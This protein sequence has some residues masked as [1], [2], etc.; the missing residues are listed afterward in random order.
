MGHSGLRGKALRHN[1][2]LAWAT[3]E[4]TPIGGR[5]RA[6]GYMKTDRTGLPIYFQLEPLTISNALAMFKGAVIRI[7]K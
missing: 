6:D 5:T 1:H 4:C 3:G 7:H 2:P